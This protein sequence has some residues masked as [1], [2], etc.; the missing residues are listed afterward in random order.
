MVA[1]A[2]S[3]AHWPVNDRAEIAS[4]SAAVSSTGSETYLREPSILEMRIAPYAGS[5]VMVMNMSSRE[6]KTVLDCGFK[7]TFM[8]DP[9]AR[10][11]ER[12]LTGK[13]SR[14]ERVPT[15]LRRSLPRAT[16]KGCSC[17]GLSCHWSSERHQLEKTS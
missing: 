15:R 16:W 8:A 14:S 3:A 4:A 10:K 9:K 12:P 7:N 5:E 17:A 6:R 13:A 1:I 2:D 11:N